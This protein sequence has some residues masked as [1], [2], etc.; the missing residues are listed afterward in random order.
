MHSLV[1]SYFNCLIFAV[2]MFQYNCL[3]SYKS[4]FSVSPTDSHPPHCARQSNTPSR[5]CQKFNKVRRK[6]LFY[7]YR[8]LFLYLFCTLLSIILR[9]FLATLYLCLSVV[10]LNEATLYQL[11]FIFYLQIRE[12]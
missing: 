8:E 12:E 2:C 4:Q 1:T 3:R 5:R 9:P 11:K 6:F 7:L 10:H